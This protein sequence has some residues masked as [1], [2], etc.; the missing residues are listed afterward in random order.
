MVFFG[1]QNRGRGSLLTLIKLIKNRIKCL[2]N[3]V[4]NFDLNIFHIITKVNSLFNFCISNL[5]F[6]FPIWFS[7]FHLS[8]EKNKQKVQV[9]NKPTNLYGFFYVSEAHHSLWIFC[10]KTSSCT[11]K[12]FLQY[13]SEDVL[14]GEM[15]CHKLFHILQYDRYAVSFFPVHYCL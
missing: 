4:K 9:L 15:F 12:V 10:H 2:R 14:V 1:E 7:N 11:Q 13:A 3:E 5:I 6:K 8:T